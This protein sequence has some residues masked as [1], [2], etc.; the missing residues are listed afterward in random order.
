MG[1]APEAMKGSQINL[2]APGIPP[3]GPGEKAPP[4]STSM[5]RFVA[6]PQGTHLAALI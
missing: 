1:S 2:P 3:P 5:T 6:A 4:L